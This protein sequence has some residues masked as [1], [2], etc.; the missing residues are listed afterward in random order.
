M[1]I[2]TKSRLITA[3][4]A[5]AA[6]AA[7]EAHAGGIAFLETEGLLDS[8]DLP[9]VRAT[10]G[11]AAVAVPIDGA[12]FESG[13]CELYVDGVRVAA[14]S[15][16]ER[17]YALAGATDGWR[18]YRLTLRSGGVD[19]VKFV[20]F[21]PYAGYVCMLHGLEA[22]PSALDA[23]PVGTVRRLKADGAMDIAWSGLW[24]AAATGA[25]VSLY[26]GD[27]P[28]GAPIGELASGAAG[29]EGAY[30]LRPNALGLAV[31]K[32]Y[33]LTHF[34]GTETLTAHLAIIGGGGFIMVV[35]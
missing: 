27:S 15:G 5:F 14:S 22:G 33:T 24:S 13:E 30:A 20:T 25:S 6:L 35:Q 11:G 18:S 2:V 9:A 28:E 31:G 1:N 8:G 10:P 21:V 19:T 16:G 3:V 34:D 23:R 26:E 4:F 32:R 29:E 12:W 7:V 17:T